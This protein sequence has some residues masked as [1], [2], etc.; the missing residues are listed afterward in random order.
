MRE[1]SKQLKNLN[2]EINTLSKY[3][4][5]ILSKHFITATLLISVYYLTIHRY[6]LSPVSIALVLNVFP[7]I[8]KSQL[9]E[10]FKKEH[11]FKLKLLKKKVQYTRLDYIANLISFIFTLFLILLWQ[12]NF[13][14]L[15]H[16]SIFI[17]I[18]PSLVLFGSL[19]IG[20]LSFFYYSI[21]MRLDLA[22][23]K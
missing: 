23:N 1:Q 2:Y 14:G 11:V 9:V 16:K 15:I 12:I 22:N 7:P 6:T 17:K 3:R 8:L 21:K 10:K 13:N 5:L 19:F 4:S 18:Y 20:L